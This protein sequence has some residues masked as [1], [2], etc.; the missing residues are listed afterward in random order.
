M[1]LFELLGKGGMGKVYRAHHLLLKKAVAIKVLQTGSSADTAT[2]EE[3]ARFTREA[4]AA[5]ALDHPNTVQ[6]L[7]YGID[8]EDRLLYIAMELI[9][10]ETLASALVRGSLEPRRACR[11]MAQI[12]AG[13]A[14]AH[15][16]GILHRDMK[17]G[18]VLLVQKKNDDGVLTDFVKVCDFGLAKVV[19][20]EGPSS[21]IHAPLT[22]LGAFLGTPTY[23][24]PE[25][26]R[27]E[28]LD[29]RT[30]V[31]SCGAI[32][33]R[34]LGGT[35][36]YLADTPWMLIEKLLTERPPALSELVPGIDP[37]LEV[38]VQWAM[39]KDRARR[40]GSAREMRKMVLSVLADLE[41]KAAEEADTV[42]GS[43]EGPTE[44]I[45]EPRPI[46]GEVS[47][48]PV[49]VV[50]TRDLRGPPARSSLVAR[51]EAGVSVGG[52]GRLHEDALAPGPEPEMRLDVPAIETSAG[53]PKTRIL[54]G[55][56]DPAEGI[57]LPSVD[58]SSFPEIIHGAP[59]PEPPMPTRAEVQS[60]L[61]EIDR[62]PPPQTTAGAET[63]VRPPGL[64]PSGARVHPQEAPARSGV[65]ARLWAGRL[66]A[67][68]LLGLALLTLF[69]I[70]WS[71]CDPPR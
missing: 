25:Q 60:A 4:R 7:D 50:P 54:S 55:S 5:S 56:R 39:E 2:E 46:G 63:G 31:Y 29:E 20:M 41:A 11:I 34:M 48:P 66:S 51:E 24:S 68:A 13:L 37:R 64:E 21:S 67:R 70:V 22:E 47:A 62:S 49:E 6:V 43:S 35:V 27:G 1:R 15:D 16:K 65:C 44:D 69:A 18:N 32:M 12:L 10:G 57:S 52:S 42:R 14:H 28:T 38:L 23:A 8:G 58:L 3:R 53:R 30:D 26:A 19:R 9:E 40:C 17:P 71:V 61:A 36:P 59:A 45:P 33:Y